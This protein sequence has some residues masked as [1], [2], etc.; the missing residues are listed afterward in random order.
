MEQFVSKEEKP[1]SI[2]WTVNCMELPDEIW[3]EIMEFLSTKDILTMAKVS[4]RFHRLSQDKDLITQLKFKTGTQRKF[5]F[6]NFH[7][8]NWT[9][10]WS[11]ERKEKYCND[12]FEVLRN[13]KKLRFLSL[14]L[15][16]PLMVV[17]YWNWIQNFVKYEHLVE[18]HIRGKNIE[19]D[20]VELGV[21]KVLN[22]C[23]KLKILKIEN[24]S[25]TIFQNVRIMNTLGE[26]K[27]SRLKL[28]SLHELHLKYS[29]CG[30]C[31]H[32]IHFFGNELRIY[33]ESLC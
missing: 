21:F 15:E 4:E 8:W 9:E 12:F 7:L 2:V 24:D 28:E 27:K 19:L 6:W 20:L 23:P 10:A 13:A 32:E 33:L 29:S 31:Y 3:M 17:F 22:Q 26:L 1:V 25:V 18:F 11:Q 5:L 30:R 14:N 16:E